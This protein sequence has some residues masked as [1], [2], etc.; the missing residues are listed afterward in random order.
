MKNQQ[1]FDVNIDIPSGNIN[2]RDITKERVIEIINKLLGDFP[3]DE[4]IQGNLKDYTFQWTR[5]FNGEYD[6]YIHGDLNFKD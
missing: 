3:K 1:K 4:F 5:L 2:E 6:I